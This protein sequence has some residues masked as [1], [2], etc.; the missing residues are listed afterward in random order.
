M[1]IEKINFNT[2]KDFYQ[3]EIKFRLSLIDYLL[4]VFKNEKKA[5]LFINFTNFI[6]L[7]KSEFNFKKFIN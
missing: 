5:I 3:I 7:V 2:Y 6:I 1:Y 4:L